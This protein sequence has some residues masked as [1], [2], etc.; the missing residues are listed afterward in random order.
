MKI[1][2]FEIKDWE[3][4]YIKERLA[5]QQ[6]FFSQLPL[7]A[8][9]LPQER[10]FE[11]ISIFTDSKINNSVIAS[12]PNL[13]LISTRTTGV[14]HIDQNAVKARNI[15]I[16]NVPTYGENTVAEYTFALLLALSRKIITAAERVKEKGKFSSEGLTGFDL[17]GKTLGVVGTGHIG[18]HVIRIAL[19]FNMKVLAFDTFPKPEL[20]KQLNFEYVSFEDLLKS[21]DV[22]TFQVPYLPSTHHLIN[23]DNLS[24]IKPGAILINTSR[25]AI[26]ET[27]AIVKA[28][29][30]GVLAGAAL[31][32]LEEETSLKNE[33]Q[34][35]LEKELDDTDLHTIVEN[36]VLIGMDN[37][38]ITPHN[39]FNSKEA[40]KRIL[41]TTIENIQSDNI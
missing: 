22:I 30:E 27:E 40:L 19:G 10:D 18:Q 12:L 20:A 32:V 37:V 1:G 35:I 14:D 5:S 33:R 8:E 23:L 31:D 11:T 9:H 15:T 36:H 39:A 13:K 16:K 29:N 24:L 17:Q 3:A 2:F 25:G 41:D 28:L 6:L 4:N 7:D 34:F 21:A 26:V 38:I